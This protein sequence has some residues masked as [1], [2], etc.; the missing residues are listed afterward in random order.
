MDVN[1][2]VVAAAQNLFAK[3]IPRPGFLERAVENL[4]TFDEFAADIYISEVNIVGIASDDHAL[5]HLV[6]VLVNDLLIFKSAG[7]RFVRVA[8][9]VDGFATLAIHKRPL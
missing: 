6:G 5:K 3:E 4:G 1:F 2:Q 8:D 7:L 9:Q